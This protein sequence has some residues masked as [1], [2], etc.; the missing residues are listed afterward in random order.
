MS[1]RAAKILVTGSMVLL[2]AACGRA[3]SAPVPAAHVVVAAPS[4]TTTTPPA[5][6]STSEVQ[7]QLQQLGYQ[8]RQITGTVDDE[9]KH[10]IVAFQKVQGLPRTGELDTATYA[11]LRSPKV[12]TAQHPTQGWHLEVDL[13][14][15][16]GYSVRNGQVDKIYDVST[17]A[18][19]GDKITPVGDFHVYYQIQGWE[20]G[21]LGN[22]YRPSYITTTGIAVHGGEA[23]EPQP[24]SNGCVR[25]TNPSVDE[26]FPQ[27]KPGTEVLIY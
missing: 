11:A 9:T 1:S 4:P 5:P 10:A 16:V 7:Q 22:L 13:T 26:L 2:V 15:Q 18:G 19:T 25:M 21:P 23:V 20:Y 24:A 12:I 3:E 6:P 8:V 17:G 14:R 27:L